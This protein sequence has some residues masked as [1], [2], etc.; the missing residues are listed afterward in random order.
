M[1]SDLKEEKEGMQ[2]I[3][4]NKE[5]QSQSQIK[6]LHRRL[7]EVSHDHGPNNNINANK[8]SV[9]YLAALK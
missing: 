7:K 4:Q 2:Q 1:E 3:V 6:Y 9:C 5:E 8:S